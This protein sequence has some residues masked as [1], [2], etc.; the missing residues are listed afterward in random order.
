MVLEHA[1]FISGGGGMSAVV[2][3]TTTRIL[4][5]AVA[6]E[7]LKWFLVTAT[8]GTV[9]IVA[10]V[11]LLNFVSLLYE[12]YFVTTPTTD[13]QSDIEEGWRERGLDRSRL[14]ME[15]RKQI[16]KQL[17][18][19]ETFLYKVET[20]ASTTSVETKN[21]NLKAQGEDDNS[22]AGIQ[23]QN[24]MRT[25]DTIASD[26]TPKK[27]LAKVSTT[28][29]R[30]IRGDLEEGIKEDTRDSEESIKKL[31]DR[32]KLGPRNEEEEGAS[33]HFSS[34]NECCICLAPYVTGDMVLRS[35]HCPHMFHAVC[36]ED[37]IV[38][39]PVCPLCI[40][41]MILDS[42]WEATAVAVLGRERYDAMLAE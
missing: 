32:D 37:W 33:E 2:V 42:E 12:K 26:D 16:V 18:A 4:Q 35:K 3:V 39:K 14:D 13:T 28:N 15:A 27:V 24:S 40:A 10:P 5:E 36:C 9:S 19:N 41:P 8:L 6:A 38:Q 23:R 29:A 7:W 17:F 22:E 31:E 30:T 20:A 11:V 1:T 21:N 25:V 34:D